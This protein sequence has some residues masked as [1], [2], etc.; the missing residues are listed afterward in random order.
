MSD[1]PSSPIRTLFLITSMPVGG[2]ETL[3]VNLVRKIDRARIEPMICC[4]KEK[5]VLGEALSEELPVFD[6]QINHKFDI[7]VAG[8]LKQLL[9]EQ[10][11]GAVITVGAGDK[12]F[13]GRLAARWARVPVVLSALHST[14]WP[15]EIGRL[16]KMLTR[17]TDGFIACADSQAQF[18]IDE[19]RLPA[20][21]VF[22]IPNGIDTER[23]Q[24]SESS[25]REWRQRIGIPYDAPTVGVVAALRPE[26]NLELFVRA[27]EAT[28]K[29]MPNAHFVIAGDGPERNALE[30]LTEAAG[31]AGRLHFLGS[32]ADIPGVLSMIDVFS[33]TSHVEAKPVSILE[34]MACGRPVV[35]T[36]VG[37]VSESVVHEQT[38]LLVAAGDRDSLA[39]SW[40]EYL[41]NL[42]LCQSVGRTARRHVVDNSSLGRMTDGYADL[43]ETMFRKK[44]RN[45][46]L[47]LHSAAT[48]AGAPVSSPPQVN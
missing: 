24:F 7:K 26:K 10:Q 12:M 46:P 18:L 16:N 11:V 27:A 44:T 36:D 1:Q 41:S 40:I 14:G 29:E 43:V 6:R 42:K 31:L 48:T 20:K 13:W 21:K 30:Q 28:V 15:D 47:L 37:S 23:F 34:A 8:R 32:V 33:L 4:L 3:L 17:V 39:A 5:G 22:V 25:K 2:A 19:E 38:G 9:R 35:A 45:R